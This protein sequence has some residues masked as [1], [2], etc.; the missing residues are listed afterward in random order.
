MGRKKDHSALRMLA[1][2][3]QLGICMMTPTFFCV[4]VGQY[5]SYKFHQE[6]IFPF[7]VLLGM[8]AGFRSCYTVITRFVNLKGEKKDSF[9]SYVMNENN[10]I[11][12]KKKEE[13]NLYEM[14]KLDSGSK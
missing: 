3:S 6:L 9:E 7:F 14:D 10:D 8:M 13:S 2:I 11:T 1:L 5:F 12:D 4:F